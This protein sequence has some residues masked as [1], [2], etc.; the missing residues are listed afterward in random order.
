MSKLNNGIGI[1]QILKEPVITDIIASAGFDLAI[2]DLEHGQHDINSIQNCVYAGHS[3]SLKTIARVPEIFYQNLVQIIDSGIDGLLFPHVET[4][5]QLNKIFEKTLLSPSGKKSF[6]PFVPKYKFGLGEVSNKV[7]PCVGIIIESALGLK[8]LDEL[9]NNSCL[10]FVYFGAYDL[11]VELNIPGE[12]FSDEI[13]DKLILLN[14]KAKKFDIKVFSIY[15]NLE[16]LKFLQS[17]NIEYPI[18]LVDTSHL[19]NILKQK[20]NEFHLTK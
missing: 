1:W 5:D 9:L 8:N 6:S 18:S 10:D 20:I 11:S 13:K 7:N 12:I 19:A 2:L 14:E 15:R 4:F 17:L 16:E 3:S